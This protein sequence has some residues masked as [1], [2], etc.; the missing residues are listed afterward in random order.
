MGVGAW[1]LAVWWTSA[2][3]GGFLPYET[4]LLDRATSLLG[5]GAFVGLAWLLS[6]HRS[7]V[8]WRPVMWG[9]AL[10]LLFGIVVL[11]ETLSG[12]FYTVVDGGVNGL[13]G[14]AEKGTT[15]AF[16]SIEPHQILIDGQATDIVG[17]VSPPV[18]TFALWI[19]PTIIFFSALM[20]ALYHLGVM[21][22]IIK[23]LARVMMKTLGTSGAE[24]LSAAG[25]I[26]VGQTE[27]P[28]LI[29]PFV[30]QMTRSE[31]MA[32]MTGGFATVAGGVMGAYV[33]FLSNIPNIAGHL[34]MASIMS[35]PAALAVAK[36]MVPETEVPVTR[37]EI[38]LDA[39]GPSSNLMEA[40][41]LG[42]RDGLFLA[43]N[44]GAML[45]AIVGLVAMVDGLLSLVPVQF[46]AEGTAFGYQCAAGSAP[47]DLSRLLGWAFAPIA[48]IMGVPWSE[49]T[50]VGSLL[51]EKVALT[52]FVAYISL[53]DRVNADVPAISERS[54][55]IASYALCGFANFASIGIQIG[56]IGSIAENKLSVLASLGF[57]AMFAGVLAACMTGAVAGLMMG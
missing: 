39:K 24:S 52:E 44:V 21:Q 48:F 10:Q 56:G 17:V 8:D 54:A 18:K 15:F 16:R 6:E 29:K 42:A 47:L 13:L 37:G 57:K 12:F 11:N 14:F 31:L 2:W 46:C 5:I 35:A 7:R 55:I 51:G 25:N 49:V 36:I 45:I 23:V 26:F 28:L 1:G 3:A 27:A 22:V 41:A 30:G 32:V 50:V 38:Q 40:V 33:Q 19:L 34:V 4:T 43:L 53:G 9:V 20:S